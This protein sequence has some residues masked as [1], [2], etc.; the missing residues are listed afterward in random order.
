MESGLKCRVGR[1]EVR[2]GGGR[3]EGRARTEHG[4]DEL[5]V[6]RSV[7]T[8]L[9]EKP[10]A[11][12]R[13]SEGFKHAVWRDEGGRVSSEGGRRF[14]CAQVAEPRRLR[15]RARCR[16]GRSGRLEELATGLL[17]GWRGGG[18]T[19]KGQW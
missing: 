1:G 12:I 16:R 5:L 2:S 18:C 11:A 8:R 19:L 9:G 3:G 14:W 6:K 10:D 4:V 17:T 15:R 7:L 13:F